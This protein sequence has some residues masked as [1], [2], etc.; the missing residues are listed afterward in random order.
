[1]FANRYILLQ[2]RVAS[3]PILPLITDGASLLFMCGEGLIHAPVRMEESNE[4]IPFVYLSRLVL[5]DR[6][7][8][9]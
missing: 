9:F 5:N 2:T 3:S 8:F 6:I 7:L 1:M 4:V